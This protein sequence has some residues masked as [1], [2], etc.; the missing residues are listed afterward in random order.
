MTENMN[1][2]VAEFVRSNHMVSVMAYDTPLVDNMSLVA[3]IRALASHESS[4]GPECP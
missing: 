3:G 4:Y 1:R 2:M